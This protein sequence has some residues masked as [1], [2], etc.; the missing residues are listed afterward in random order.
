MKLHEGKKVEVKVE[1]V[2][3]KVLKKCPKSNYPSPQYP[4]TPNHSPISPL[5]P[6]F[7]SSQLPIFPLYPLA[8]GGVQKNLPGQEPWDYLLEKMSIST[9]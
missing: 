7:L 6:T 9:Y 1:N 8:T 3:L 4:I 2:L 5:F